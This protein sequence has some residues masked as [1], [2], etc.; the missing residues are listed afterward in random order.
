[1]RTEV[2]VLIQREASCA[3]NVLADSCTPFG[4]A[5]KWHV[6]SAM[7]LSFSTP[8]VLV[9]LL[10]FFALFLVS[11]T[12]HAPCF[13][14]RHIS[15][16]SWDSSGSWKSKVA[17]GFRREPHGTVGRVDTVE[18]AIGV[19]Q[20]LNVDQCPSSKIDHDLDSNCTGNCD[21]FAAFT[22]ARSDHR[23]G[24]PS[25]E[26]REVALRQVGVGTASCGRVGCAQAGERWPRARAKQG[27]LGAL[28]G[29]RGNNTGGLGDRCWNRVPQTEG[30][31]KPN[32]A[33]GMLPFDDDQDAPPSPLPSPPVPLSLTAGRRTSTVRRRPPSRVSVSDGTLLQPCQDDSR[34]WG[35]PDSK[36]NS[37]CTEKAST[38]G[39]GN[40]AASATPRAA[41]IKAPGGEE[42]ISPPEDPFPESRGRGSIVGLRGDGG[43]E[44]GVVGQAP[45]TAG[46][47][48]PQPRLG[49][50]TRPP[51]MVLLQDTAAPATD[52]VPPKVRLQRE[53][54][55]FSPASPSDTKPTPCDGYKASPTSSPSAQ[56]TL[57]TQCA[58]EQA[59]A[60]A[61][62]LHAT[63][64]AGID[65]A[66]SL[67]SSTTASH[68]ASPP[69]HLNPPKQAQ[70][71]KTTAE[72]TL[73]R[74]SRRA[75][76]RRKGSPGPEGGA[77]RRTR[78]QNEPK[79][80]EQLQPAKSSTSTAQHHR[81]EAQMVPAVHAHA[82]ASPVEK[83]PVGQQEE[84]SLL[85]AEAEP[86]RSIGVVLRYWED[87]PIRDRS[88]EFVRE[89]LVVASAGRD[90][91]GETPVPSSPAFARNDEVS[92]G[93]PMDE[94]SSG[95]DKSATERR[96]PDSRQDDDTIQP[97]DPAA[98]E[99]TA[100]NDRAP[101]MPSSTVLFSVPAPRAASL[102]LELPSPV[103]DARREPSKPPSEREKSSSTLISPTGGGR[104]RH[105]RRVQGHDAL[106][107]FVS[108][109]AMVARDTPCFSV[110]ALGRRFAPA[111]VG[112]KGGAGYGLT[113]QE[114]RLRPSSGQ[115]KGCSTSRSFRSP[116]VIDA[117]DR[118]NCRPG[119][120][121]PAV[122][123]IPVV[124][125]HGH[126]EGGKP[127]VL[128]ARVFA[129]QVN[130]NHNEDVGG[131]PLLDAWGVR[132]PLLTRS[133]GKI[134]GASNR[135]GAPYG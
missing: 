108:N 102:S 31:G 78:E 40:D 11:R 106:S 115:G 128:L 117:S 46:T 54:S 52:D 37:L 112:F 17:P 10:C 20:A 105:S 110:E 23:E 26:L 122:A 121:V 63:T 61:K 35:A 126:Q 79:K 45:H 5:T 85:P 55:I 15:R 99:K 103:P 94:P 107:S 50:R 98:Q 1:M 14:P 109:H 101:E 70:P 27:K 82:G 60:Q 24:T 42:P 134:S 100:G 81:R 116:F 53:A 77:A 96:R 12:P 9:L 3:S 114:A 104:N 97:P 25:G 51:E 76:L 69:V 2:D 87:D 75:I 72:L 118:K 90:A 65:M 93:H 59:G 131:N 133:P 6:Y 57:S 124:A 49:D 8:S 18:G 56:E 36:H 28:E 48:S 39:M 125:S 91:F 43:I 33:A 4:L 95:A 13:R 38:F 19:P 73:Q 47:S 83:N 130:T 86:R 84:V 64:Y 32:A 111:D 80:V 74:W 119:A 44:K 89:S 120:V 92:H 113:V 67:S 127:S 68:K 41:K 123:E 16:I 66:V 132:N 7:I 30:R 129:R 71:S 22:S 29:C 34:A 62:E 135:G 21:G 58:G 88:H